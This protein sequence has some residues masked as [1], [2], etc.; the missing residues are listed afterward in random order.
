M[1]GLENNRVEGYAFTNLV[2]DGK[3]VTWSNYKSHF[4]LNFSGANGSNQDASK[5]VRNVTFNSVRNIHKITVTE[6]PGGNVFPKGNNGVIDCPDGTSQTL[7]II[8]NNGYKIKKVVVDGVEVQRIQVKHFENV[9]KD[10]T[11]YVEFEQGD[12]YFDLLPT[13][14][15]F[16]KTKF[17]SYSLGI[18]QSLQ[19]GRVIV[20]YAIP[21]SGKVTF[22][23]YTSSGKKV[24][25]KIIIH[26]SSGSYKLLWDKLGILKSGMYFLVML[27]NKRDRGIKRI[28]KM[29]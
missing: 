9:K 25:H 10:H 13:P 5:W 2:V 23:V 27:H 12:D 17:N 22:I 7:S 8:P 19:N 3:L 11:L 28:I 6:G 21:R 1:A 26:E 14:I 24:G 20:N 4:N 16:F 15:H 29:N 18:Q